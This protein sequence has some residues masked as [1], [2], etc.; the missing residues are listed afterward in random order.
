[1]QTLAR[2]NHLNTRLGNYAFGPNWESNV[3]YLDNI[4]RDL[5]LAVEN[6]VVGTVA[7]MNATMF[8]IENLDVTSTSYEPDTGILIN[9]SFEYTG[10]PDRDRPYSGHSLSLM[11][12][13]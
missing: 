7:D 13:L 12:R 3:V 6:E 5:D 11:G 9:V 8:M 4:F 2:H 1:M 10:E